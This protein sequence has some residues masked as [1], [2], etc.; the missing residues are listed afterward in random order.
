VNNNRLARWN[1]ASLGGGLESGLVAVIEYRAVSVEF[2]T[3]SH[4]MKLFPDKLDAHLA[5]QTAPIYFLHG[6]EPYQLMQLGDKLREHAR[7]SGF[8]ERQVLIANDDADWSSFREAA[9]SMS[10]FAEQRII[11]LRLPTGKPGRTGGEVLKQYCANPASDVLL[12]ITS[13]KLDRGGSSSAWF[14]AIDKVGVT[15]AVWPIEPAKLRRWL[16][17]KLAGHGLQATDDAVSL[18]TERV[19]GNMLAA[20]QEVERLALLYPKGELSVDQVLSAVSDSARYSIGDLVQASLAGQS[21][22]AVRIVRGL[23]DEAVAPVLILWSLSQEIRSGT[24]AAEAHERGVAIDAAL[25][26]AGVWQSRAAPLKAAMGRHNAS[27]WLSMLVASTQ[28]DRLVKG[29]ASGDVWDTFE[30]L[31]V[32]LAGNAQTRLPIDQPDL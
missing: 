21:A 9:D 19:E 15:I 7:S 23:R 12:I 1:S 30:S 22:R 13:A 3:I 11:E 24:R 31:C 16:S 26:G 32:Q 18:I 5:R 29:H 14:K 28:L 6:D 8:D 27:S 25:K 17:D 2:D 20:A 4:Y 10:L